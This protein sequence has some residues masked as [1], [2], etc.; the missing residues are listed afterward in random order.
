[1]ET[2]EALVDHKK[3]RYDMADNSPAAGGMTRRQFFKRWVG[4]AAVAVGAGTWARSIEP[5]WVDPGT[6]CP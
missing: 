1:M 5:F 3:I 6:T 2:L 4:G